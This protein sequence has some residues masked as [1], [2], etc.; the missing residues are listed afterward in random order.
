MARTLP[1][2]ER[3]KRTKA[4]QALGLDDRRKF[5]A[6]ARA[7]SLASKFRDKF[8]PEQLWSY[9]EKTAEEEVSPRFFSEQLPASFKR[10]VGEATA[11]TANLGENIAKFGDYVAGDAGEKMLNN[12][13]LKR[14]AG[15]GID[16]LE[17]PQ[18]EDEE[19]ESPKD[20]REVL[21]A[22]D[23]IEDGGV[24]RLNH[25]GRMRKWGQELS[26]ENTLRGRT[27]V[28]TVVDTVAAGVGSMLPFIPAAGIARVPMGILK[29]KKTIGLAKKLGMGRKLRTRGEHALREMGTLAGA[30]ALL[31]E[32]GYRGEG[33]AHGAMLGLPIAG[34]QRLRGWKKPTLAGAALFGGLGA[35]HGGTPAEVLGE[36]LTGGFFFGM[37]PFQR[38]RKRR[39]IQEDHMRRLEEADIRAASEKLRWEQDKAVEQKTLD[40]G[41]ETP[42]YAVQDIPQVPMVT[43]RGA[44]TSPGVHQPELPFETPG[45]H[46]PRDVSIEPKY[47]TLHPKSDR[48]LYLEALKRKGEVTASQTRVTERIRPVREA[49]TRV[50]EL[51]HENVKMLHEAEARIHELETLAVRTKGTPQHREVVGLLEQMR[52]Q[53]KSLTESV[54][55]K[56]E[57]AG[58]MTM[59]G[60]DPVPV[61]PQPKV[62][63]GPSVVDRVRPKGDQGVSQPE[64][65]LGTAQTGVPLESGVTRTPAAAS[66]IADRAPTATATPI[67]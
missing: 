18:G 21:S 23:A 17:T 28:G 44:R 56:G 11:A 49:M 25:Y 38:A 63:P 9:A 67:V 1:T 47:T 36:A 3:L 39:A 20:R 10:G 65:P 19:R 31:S 30:E 12:P 37:S 58:Q 46:L 15:G 6:R 13:L 26:T 4:Y 51:R 48:D 35:H 5:I 42:Q 34:I 59:F 33:A 16:Y 66:S 60:R 22:V 14:F 61:Q 29:A 41:L 2:I 64:L 27:P 8:T 54:Y 45:G 43:G 62:S 57:A 50:E 53:V 55:G 32:E 7:S 40:L 52:A 24:D